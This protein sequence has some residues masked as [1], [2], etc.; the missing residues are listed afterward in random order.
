MG[1][2]I[3]V[4]TGLLKT[5]IDTMNTSLSQ[6]RKLMEDVFADIKQL[7]TMWDG[8]ANAEFNRQFAMDY[9]TM[10]DQCDTIED[11][12]DHYDFADKEY[13]KCENE[14]DAIVKSIRI[15]I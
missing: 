15:T 4:D 2:E 9:Q 11:M 1:K 14:V 3:T 6:L 5:D 7:D 10:K 12:I 8:P 13:V